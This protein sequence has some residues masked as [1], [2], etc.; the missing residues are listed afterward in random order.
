MGVG[1]IEMKHV[2]NRTR[3]YPALTMMEMIIAMVIMAVVFAV[4]VPQL[5]A[6]QGSWDT[7]AGNVETLQNA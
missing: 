6:I 4:L 3:S 5:R 7:K 1:H 2:S